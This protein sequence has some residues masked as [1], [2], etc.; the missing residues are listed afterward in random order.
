M[1]TK[2]V[3]DN[4]TQIAE[5]FA[6]QRRERQQ[7]TNLDKADFDALAAAGVLLTGAPASMGGLWVDVATSTRPF[8]E[9]LRVLAT[10]DPSVALVTAMH[11]AVLGFWFTRPEAPPP[12]TQAWRAQSTLLYQTALDGHWWGTVTS[13]PGSGGDVTRS[14]ATASKQSDGR[15]RISGQKHFGSGSGI[16]SYMITTAVP[17]GESAADFFYLDMRGAV[18]SSGAPSDVSGGIKLVAPWD[19]Y[20]MSATQSHAFELT[21]YPAQRIA[22]PGSQSAVT[23]VAGAFFGALFTAVVVGVVQSA[24]DAA[25]QR[26]VPRREALRRYEAVEWARIETECW[27]I[28]QAYER[29]LQLMEAKGPGALLDS[30]HAKLAIAELAESVTQR[31]CRVIGGGSFSRSSHFGAAFEDVRALG[32]LRPPWALAYD[33]LLD[34]TWQAYQG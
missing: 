18:D 17:E 8:C 24:H 1:E 30:Q 3:I 5:G 19:G 23:G 6:A 14:K 15:F 26:I 2:T 11:P 9:L 32:F 7:R 16:S 20:G 31:I 4:V 13:E 12:H 10:G 33:Q 34:R 29:L 28:E 21:D 22:W 27:L 25:A